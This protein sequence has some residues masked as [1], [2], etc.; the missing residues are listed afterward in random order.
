MCWTIVTSSTCLSAD[1]AAAYLDPSAE[2]AARLGD[3]RFFLDTKSQTP[4]ARV[5]PF[6]LNTPHFADYAHLRRFLW[7]PDGMSI[8]CDYTKDLVY[9]V[10]A[11]LIITI[12]YLHDLR[13]PSLGEKTIETRLLIHKEDGWKAAQYN[14]NEETTEARLSVVGKSAEVSWTHYDGT[15]RNHTYRAPNSNQCKQ[16]H[17][18]EGKMV[19]LGPTTVARINRV[20]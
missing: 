1:T 20:Y 14:W 12:L 19:P 4:N 8:R 13:D 16:C 5:L 9:P 11:V 18:I 15:K 10:G 2:P 17:E 3:Y 6:D 7:L